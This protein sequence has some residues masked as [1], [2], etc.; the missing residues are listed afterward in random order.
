MWLCVF[1]LAVE[2]VLIRDYL[3]FGD[4][5]LISYCFIIELL[6][7][8]NILPSKILYHH[9]T[10]HIRIISWCNCY[11][12]FSVFYHV[13]C[14]WLI[15]IQISW[16]YC[17]VQIFFSTVVSRIC[18]VKIFSI[19]ICDFWGLYLAYFSLGIELIF[20]STFKAYLFQAV[21]CNRSICLS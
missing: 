2:I 3:H 4:L 13:F 16:L 7:L 5:I 18:T 21:T 10:W 12:I 8:L 20:V 11:N 6:I 15:L 17:V 14:Y 19:R 1:L 9:W